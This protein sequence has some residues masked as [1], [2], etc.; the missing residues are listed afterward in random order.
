MIAVGIAAAVLVPPPGPLESG[1][2][3]AALYVVFAFIASAYKKVRG[4]DGLGQGDWK[5][6]AMLGAFLG[7]QGALFAV[8]AGAVLGSVIGGLFIALSRRGSQYALPFG[9]FLALGGVAAIFAGQQFLALVQRSSWTKAM[10]SERRSLI[11]LLVAL[12]VGTGVLSLWS[13][14]ERHARIRQTASSSEIRR[15]LPAGALARLDRAVE[16]DALSMR[17]TLMLEGL[18]IAGGLAVAVFAF[19]RGTT[20]AGPEASQTALRCVRG[21]HGTDARPARPGGRAA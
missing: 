19:G 15:Q 14:L 11:T 20:A 21:S 1:L 8:F 16:A 7:W 12:L 13:S 9:T 5:M 6:A 2:S 3:A 10:H 4:I 17:T 18:L